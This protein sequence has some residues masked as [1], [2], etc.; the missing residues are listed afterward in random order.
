MIEINDPRFAQYS[1]L[2]PGGAFG[3]SAIYTHHA[4]HLS[5]LRKVL[6]R[7]AAWMNYLF[8]FH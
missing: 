7:M 2:I 3:Q 4:N 6:L 5:I 1:E 8:P